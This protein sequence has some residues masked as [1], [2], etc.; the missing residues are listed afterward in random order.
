MKILWISNDPRMAAVGQS[1]VSREI[2]NRLHGYGIEVHTV[3]I[4]GPSSDFAVPYPVYGWSAERHAYPKELIGNLRPEVIICSHDCWNFYWLEECRRDFPDIKQVGYYTIDGGPIHGSWRKTMRTLDLLATPTRFGKEQ[5]YQ[6]YPE[7]HVAVIPYGVDH[8]RFKLDMPKAEKKSKT[9]LSAKKPGQVRLSSKCLFT[10]VGNN[11]GRKNVPCILDAFHD[12]NMENSHLLMVTH[13]G[14][15]TRGGW[16]GMADSDLIDIVGMYDHRERITISCDSL[17]E[18]SLVSLYQCSDYFVLPSQGEAPGLPILEAMACGCIPI[19]TGYAGA[20]EV[21][22]GYI[23]PYTPLRGEF[24]VNRAIVDYR[25]LSETMVT[26]YKAWE[27][28]ENEGHVKACID[29]VRG[30]S[31][32]ATGF[33]WSQYL[34][35]VMAGKTMVD[36]G[37]D[38]CL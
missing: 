17:S 27:R 36:T 25:K 4:G 15:Q 28:N 33:M 14:V 18:E 12:A 16:T 6:R 19:V 30:L 7:K 8:S 29:S 21:A 23:L 11:Q 9:D 26:A 37:V 32:D 2:L 31:W 35:G 20:A 1:R 10:F 5:I 24:N 3:G 13:V 34:Q 22:T 38:K